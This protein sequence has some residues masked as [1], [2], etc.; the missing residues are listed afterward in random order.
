M[1]MWLG[2]P[3]SHTKMTDLRFAALPPRGA[4]RSRPGSVSPPTASAPTFSNERRFRD[5]SS[6]SQLQSSRVSTG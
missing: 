5:T 3:A 6:I 2:P 4:A 1:S